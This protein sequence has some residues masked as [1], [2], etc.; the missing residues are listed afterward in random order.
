[1]FHVCVDHLDRSFDLWKTAQNMAG[2]ARSR[3]LMQRE[4]VIG[5]VANSCDYLEKTIDELNMSV[6]EKNHA[7]LAKMR[8]EL[9]E[10]IQVARK[11][12]QRTQSLT[13]GTKTYDASEFE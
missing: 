5:E 6:T 1:M 12:E 8:N 9:D 7:D 10:T 2:E 4:A 3:I 13:D 11:A